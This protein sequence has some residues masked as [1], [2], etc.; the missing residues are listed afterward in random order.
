MSNIIEVNQGNF[1]SEVIERS[2]RMP[3]VVDFWAPWCGP[4]RML[5]PILE[6]LA[7]EPNSGFILAK[8]NTDQNQALAMQY[9]IR[10]IP[11]VKAFRDGRVVDEFVGAQPEPMVRQFLQR[12]RSSARQTPPQPQA[13]S[14]PVRD[15]AQR[16]Q[17]AQELL[18]Q[19]NGCEALR[20]LE[21]FPSSPQ[22]AEATRLLPLARFLCHPTPAGTAELD[23]LYSQAASALRR[24]DYGAA[25]YNLL[26]AYNREKGSG[27]QRAGEIMQ[28]VFALVGEN[29]PVASQYRQL[30]TTV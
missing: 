13:T 17:Q 10:G 26:T 24:R 30:I 27:Q 2:H 21:K 25:L 4:C 20:L 22:A 29:D 8:L 14:A 7:N 18:R 6:R 12:V 9:G 23:N 5:G 28:G 11:A 16:L 15:P 19:G 3:V 1:Q